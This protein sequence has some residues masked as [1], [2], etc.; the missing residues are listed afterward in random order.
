MSALYQEDDRQPI[1]GYM[2]PNRTCVADHK[3]IRLFS[4]ASTGECREIDAPDYSGYL[5]IEALIIVVPTQAVWKQAME[6]PIPDRLPR[7]YFVGKQFFSAD[8]LSIGAY[9]SDSGSISIA[10]MAQWETAYTRQARNW[11]KQVSPIAKVED[12]CADKLGRDSVFES[13]AGAH[14]VLYFGHGYYCGL[15]GYHG[16]TAEHFRPNRPV[17]LF[18]S[19]SCNTLYG[20]NSFA[21]RL[22]QAGLVKAYIGTTNPKAR[23]CDNVRLAELSSD[24]L[25]RERPT[26]LME[27]VG[28]LD[29]AVHATGDVQLRSA[30]ADYLVLGDITLKL[31]ELSRDNR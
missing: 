12:F 16:I 23:S 5:D 4:V 30:W 26:A 8:A 27:W 1:N 11:H 31:P 2:V 24:V 15:D 7:S 22:L 20:R 9:H 3:N 6:L 13:I 18:W 10:V 25:L 14:V 21:L 17:G 28:K 29:M 19:W